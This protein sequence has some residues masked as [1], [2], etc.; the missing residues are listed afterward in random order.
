MKAT[1][2]LPPS[3]YP[4]YRHP[5]QVFAYDDLLEDHE[6]RDYDANPPRLLKKSDILRR[7]VKGKPVDIQHQDARKVG[8]LHDYEIRG[9]HLYARGYVNDEGYKWIKQHERYRDPIE[10]REKYQRVGF[11]VTFDALKKEYRDEKRPCLFK[12]GAFC[13]DPKRVECYV[14]TD[15]SHGA[16]DDTTSGDDHSVNNSE[17]IGGGDGE[18]GRVRES[19]CDANKMETY[20]YG[21]AADQDIQLDFCSSQ[22]IVSDKPTMSTTTTDAI[23]ESVKTGTESIVTNTTGVSDIVN[24]NN[25]DQQSGSKATDTTTT[26]TS[27]TNQ[28]STQGTSNLSP[29]TNTNSAGATGDTKQQ[30]S[31]NTTNSNNNGTPGIPKTFEEYSSN[32]MTLLS[33]AETPEQKEELTKELLKS[34]WEA[35]QYNIQVKAREK[36][37]Y[38]KRV[39]AVKD[40]IP[41]Y[42]RA[43]FEAE[44]DR[45]VRH[46]RLLKMIEMQ[47]QQTTPPKKV[48]FTSDTTNNNNTKNSSGATN[49]KGAT[50]GGN[51]GG[52]GAQNTEKKAPEKPNTTEKKPNSHNFMATKNQF[53]QL[54]KGMLEQNSQ[55]PQMPKSNFF[56]LPTTQ[57]Q[58]YETKAFSN[59]RG[60]GDDTITNNNNEK[61]K[62][63][64][65]EDPEDV[66][67]LEN[68]SKFNKKVHHWEFGNDMGLRQVLEAEWSMLAE[69]QK[70]GC[71]FHELWHQIKVEQKIVDN[72]PPR[73]VEKISRGNPIK[74]G[75]ID[76]GF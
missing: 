13:L 44:Y 36:E 45:G 19:E 5:F 9:R 23:T 56:N 4:E 38:F 31:G 70:R 20:T 6:E 69:Q 33:K 43:E 73:E 63:K 76:D 25:K 58:Q 21:Y 48:G 72:K 7:G 71:E 40:R 27:A 60:S 74:Y 51:G 18:N 67:D 46:D 3:P 53:T 57:Q 28:S 10:K 65:N 64:K 32:M 12:G 17:K 75:G 42:N 50:A 39:E 61:L 41:D 54:L 22:S 55:P 16:R 2:G 59:D 47:P 29:A 30:S 15:Y 49:A 66:D 1:S 52:A 34:T 37:E 62:R 24:N 14:K 8:V 26:T 68:D 35:Q 11:S